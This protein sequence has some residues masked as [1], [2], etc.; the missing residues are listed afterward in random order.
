MEEA[1]SR[2]PTMIHKYAIC[3][4]LTFILLL[5]ILMYLLPFVKMITLEECV[6]RFRSIMKVLGYR[7]DNL[8]EVGISSSK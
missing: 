5:L 1:K 6:H 7:N 2:S 3:E 8:E 4:S